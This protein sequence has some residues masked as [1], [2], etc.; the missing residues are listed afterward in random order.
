MS[1][2][3]APRPQAHLDS[4]E[5]TLRESRLKMLIRCCEDRI[6]WLSTGSRLYFGLV[7]GSRVA[8]LLES[9][10]Q[11]W[12]EG[13]ESEEHRSAARLLFTEQLGGKEAVYLVQFGSHVS[14][15]VPDPLPFTHDKKR[16]K[17]KS[18]EYMY[19]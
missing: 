1:V 11:L 9:S 19:L 12:R 13:K 5:L 7:K 4:A 2:H 14:P 6:R 15:T 17:L 10:D 3:S 8:F 16:C 18:I